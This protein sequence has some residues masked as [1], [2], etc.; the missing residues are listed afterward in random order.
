M[1]L[2]LRLIVTAHQTAAEEADFGKLGNLQNL[3]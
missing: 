2:D 1:A 3:G